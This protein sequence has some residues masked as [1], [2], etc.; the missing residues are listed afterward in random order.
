MAEESIDEKLTAEFGKIGARYEGITTSTDLR[1]AFEIIDG[2]DDTRKGLEDGAKDDEY[3]NPGVVKL[4][5]KKLKK[6][7]DEAPSDEKPPFPGNSIEEYI[8]IK[9]QQAADASHA[10]ANVI[11]SFLTNSHA[12][13]EIDSAHGS[14]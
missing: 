10:K 1:K 14:S 6:K 8:E 12:S 7:Y 2:V 5:Y 9:V 11:F 4:S 3:G 13:K